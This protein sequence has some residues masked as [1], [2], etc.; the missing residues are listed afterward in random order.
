MIA[1]TIAN[2]SYLI[3]GKLMKV[4]KED[5]VLVL[6]LACTPACPDRSGG[7]ADPLRAAEEPPTFSTQAAIR[8]FM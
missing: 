8:L 1:L 6:Y 2:V 4:S 5:A 7:I 3:I